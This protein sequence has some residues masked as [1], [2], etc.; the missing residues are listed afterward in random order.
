MVEMTM[1]VLINEKEEKDSSHIRFTFRTV[2][3]SQGCG[4]VCLG[5]REKTLT[6]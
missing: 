4:K 6:I 2:V 5:V 1:M 3:L